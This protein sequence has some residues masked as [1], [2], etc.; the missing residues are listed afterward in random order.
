MQRRRKEA[1]PQLQNKLTNLMRMILNVFI[2][3]HNFAFNPLKMAT[4]DEYCL[5][6]HE[7]EQSDTTGQSGGEPI[8][9]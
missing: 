4:S 1:L 8:S 6:D 5:Q 2:G 7:A 3:K 9:H